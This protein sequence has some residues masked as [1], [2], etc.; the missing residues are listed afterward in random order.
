LAALLNSLNMHISERKLRK[1]FG[2]FYDDYR[3]LRALI[4]NEGVQALAIPIKIQ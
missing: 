2:V 1:E 4:D 3:S